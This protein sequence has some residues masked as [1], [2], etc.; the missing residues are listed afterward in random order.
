[1]DYITREEFYKEFKCLKDKLNNLC[2]KIDN[3]TNLR[4]DKSNEEITDTQFGVVEVSEGLNTA[5]E[6]ITEIQLALIELSERG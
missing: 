6:E 3:F 4:I 1:M 2:Q 5:A